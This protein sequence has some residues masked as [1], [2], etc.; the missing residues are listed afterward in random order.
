MKLGRTLAL[1]VLALAGLFVWAPV[2]RADRT[3]P[4]RDAVVCTPQVWR[5]GC[6]TPISLNGLVQLLDAHAALLS[7]LRFLASHYVVRADDCHTNLGSWA[8]ADGLDSSGQ[9]VELTRAAGAESQLVQK[10]LNDLAFGFR[11]S[12][13]TVTLVSGL[14]EP[15]ESWRLSGVIPLSW[16]IQL[17]PGSKVALETLDLSHQGL[18]PADPC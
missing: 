8:K 9:V 4:P 7:P 16:S 17:G 3:S 5:A 13:A 18:T 6:T 2:T 10:W 12:D 15:L 11:Q 1:L 14:G